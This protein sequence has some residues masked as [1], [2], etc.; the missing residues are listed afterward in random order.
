[1]FVGRLFRYERA[2]DGRWRR[3]EDAVVISFRTRWLPRL[4]D[5]AVAAAVVG[6]CPPW[7]RRLKR[8]TTTASALPLYS[9]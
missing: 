1:M 7:T 5:A 2:V 8:T 9:P 3:V 4:A 6:Q